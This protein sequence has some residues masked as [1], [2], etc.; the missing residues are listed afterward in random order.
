MALFRQREGQEAEEHTKKRKLTA[1]SCLGDKL[2]KAAT[3]ELERLVSGMEQRMSK[4]RAV[5]MEL[6]DLQKNIHQLEEENKWPSGYARPGVGGDATI[7]DTPINQALARKFASPDE[8]NPLFNCGPTTTMG[9]LKFI[10]RHST[11]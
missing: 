4:R 8:G 6:K 11:P 9:Q 3:D 1:A 5:R 2:P 10:V 7:L